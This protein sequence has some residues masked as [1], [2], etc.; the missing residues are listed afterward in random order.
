[1]IA[2][3][4]LIFGGIGC[5]LGLFLAKKDLVSWDNVSETYNKIKDFVKKDR[6]TT[7]TPEVRTPQ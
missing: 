3:D 7:T 1:M 6:D 5:L 2:I 4:T